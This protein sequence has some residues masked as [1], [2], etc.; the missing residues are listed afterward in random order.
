MHLTSQTKETTFTK[1]K[2]SLP[3]LTCTLRSLLLRN[4]QA[5]EAHTPSHER[6]CSARPCVSNRI[7]LSHTS[8]SVRWLTLQVRTWKRGVRSTT[9]YAVYD[10]L[11][12]LLRTLAL[13]VSNTAT[14]ASP[15][16]L[17]HTPKH[18]VPLLVCASR[19]FDPA[20]VG[21]DAG[22]GFLHQGL[23]GEMWRQL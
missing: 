18:R 17:R 3:T 21:S 4:Q 9:V 12:D 1:A 22:F 8:L 11:F 19:S 6:V 13:P 2:H 23:D 10:P 14:T 20:H 5:Y 7:T 16:T 15:L